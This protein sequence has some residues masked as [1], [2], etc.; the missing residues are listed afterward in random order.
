MHARAGRLE[1]D[2]L[3]IGSMFNAD[4]C[5]KLRVRGFTLLNVNGNGR[6]L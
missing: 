6:G 3:P 2:T 4:L 1:K 5:V